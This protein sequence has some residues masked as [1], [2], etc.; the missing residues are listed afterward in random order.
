[1]RSDQ[2]RPTA[3]GDKAVAYLRRAASNAVARSADA[4]AILLLD[5]A[6]TALSH[7]PDD[8]TTLQQGVDV[9]LEL[10]NALLPLGDHTRIYRCH[11]RKRNPA[12]K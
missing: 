10:R 8:L 12:S 3:E 5:Q 6:V 11:C 4:D 2:R 7:L 9:R 1:L